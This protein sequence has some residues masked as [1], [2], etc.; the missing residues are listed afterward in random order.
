LVSDAVA[1]TML[2]VAKRVRAA[3]ALVLP[4]ILGSV[5]QIEVITNAMELRKFGTQKRRTWIMSRPF[6]AGDYLTIAIGIGMMAFVVAYNVINGSR[7]WN[8]FT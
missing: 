3:A 1:S 6:K 7:F 2:R 8:P 5:E 4:L